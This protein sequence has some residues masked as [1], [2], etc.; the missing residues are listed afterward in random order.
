MGELTDA[1]RH[2]DRERDA[3]EPQRRTRERLPEPPAPEREAAEPAPVREPAGGA[4]VEEATDA[5]AIPRSRDAAWIA[6]AVVVDEQA[7]AAECYRQ[8]AL[9]VR[10]AL[11]EGSPR[12]LLVT[13]ALRR[14]GKTT[15]S[16]NLALALASMAGSEGRIALV[17]LDLHRPQVARGLGLRVAVGFD[18]VLEGSTALADARIRTDVPSLDVFA[19]SRPRPQAHDVLASR[20]LRAVLDELAHDYDTVVIDTPPVLLVPDVGLMAS[21]VGGWVAVVRSGETLRSAFLE[22]LGLLS[23]ARLVGCFLNDAPLPRHV[24]QYEHAYYRADDGD[25]GD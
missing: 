24:R 5:A 1:L 2:A 4:P 20:R 19:V 12:T 22:M 21:H 3:A 9:R 18:Q 10:R 6:R 17:D 11:E 8:L 23:H 15:T 25:E 16:C 14:E 13:S 7:R